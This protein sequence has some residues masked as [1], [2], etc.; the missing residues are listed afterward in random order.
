[1]SNPLASIIIPT[2]KRPITLERAIDSALNQTY[3]NIEVLV[4]DDNNPNSVDRKKTI[5]LMRK[6]KANSKVIY[7]IMGANG[8]ACKARNKGIDECKGKYVTFLDDDDEYFPHKIEREIQ[9]MKKGY[10]M[11]FSNIKICDVITNRCFIQS[12]KQDFT[13]ERKSLLRKHFVDTISGGIAFMYKRKK[14][15]EIGKFYEIDANQEYILMLNTIISDMKIGYLNE[16]LCRSHVDN[17]KPRI[18]NNKKVI[19]AKIEVVRLIKPHLKE[20]NFLD[21]RKTLARLYLFICYQ[22]FKR[23]DKRFWQYGF[24]L[25]P[26]LDLI[27]IKLIKKVIRKDVYIK[28]NVIYR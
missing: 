11:I 24:K 20:I 1:M 17:S 7:L 3:K 16:T 26:Y 19:D 27:F 2:H 22:S 9:M 14:I 10:D 6:Y 13:F 25:I 23:K 18:S 21:R 12:Y 4:I 8:G 15:I 28:E 5:K